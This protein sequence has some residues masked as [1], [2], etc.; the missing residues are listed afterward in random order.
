MPVS[1]SDMKAYLPATVASSFSTASVGGAISATE[2]NGNVG[3][4]LFTA[5]AE[6][7]GGSDVTQYAKFFIKNTHSTDPINSYV[8]WVANSLDEITSASTVSLV[9]D[10]ASD[11]S[12]TTAVVRGFSSG[13][14]P[15]TES[16][17]LNG[18]T[19]VTTT[20]TF[21]GNVRVYLTNT[22]TGALKAAVGEV[23]VSDSSTIGVIPAG[24]RSATGEVEIGIESTLG[25]STT[26]ALP[27]VAPSGVT[28]SRPRT[29][30][31]GITVDGGTGTLEA[32]ETQAVWIKLTLADGTLPSTSVDFI[33][34]G[35]GDAV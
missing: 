22:S 5:A 14:S 34:R 26:I 35:K 2:F 24:H 11:D 32:G 19:T 10:N 25:G 28:F 12:T 29:E 1:S 9:S 21:L 6:A 23:T 33:L 15:Q 27:N 17:P 16:V 7:S 13:G 31:G 8:I 18:T 4:L 3:Q 20:N 30:A